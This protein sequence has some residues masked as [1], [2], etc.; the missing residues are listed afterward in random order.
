MYLK[1]RIYKYLGTPKRT[2][3][4]GKISF[5]LYMLTPVVFYT[6]LQKESD[7]G[8]SP[9]STA[10]HVAWCAPSLLL[11]AFLCFTF[12]HSHRTPNNRYSYGLL[13]LL[14]GLAIFVNEVLVFDLIMQRMLAGP[15]NIHA[16]RGILCLNNMFLMLV[17]FFL[18]VYIRGIQTRLNLYRAESE[19]AE[20]QFRLL[21]NQMNPHFLFN[22]LNVAASLPYE[23]AER[24][25]RFIK[26]LGSVYRYM[27]QTSEKRCVTL[28]EEMEFADSFCYLEKVRFEEKLQIVTTIDEQLLERMVVPGSVQMLIEN[29]VKHNTVSE[30]SPLRVTIEADEEGVTVSNNVQLRSP[31]APQGLGLQNLSQQYAQL[32]RKIEVKKDDFQFTVRLPFV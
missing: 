31:E 29:A 26:Q 2:E 21:K 22:A 9:H 6:S 24:A 3:A 23:D 12:R 28:R 15:L 19:R 17:F 18:Y 25:S 1:E 11:L 10:L 8:L 27:L 13:L 32:K 7:Y 4:I 14:P 5:V 30:E 20:F 16:E